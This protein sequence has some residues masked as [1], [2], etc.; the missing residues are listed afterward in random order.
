ML[1]FN[2]NHY[3]VLLIA[4]LTM[5]SA[6]ESKTTGKTGTLEFRYSADDDF[7]NFNKP[8][9]VGAKLDLRVFKAGESKVKATVESATSED[10]AVLKIGNIASNVVTIEAKAA[11]S[12]ELSFV[13]DAGEDSIDMMARVPEVLKVQHLC[14]SQDEKEGYY[15]QKQDIFIPF[16]MELKDG[17]SV[18]GYGYYPVTFDKETVTLDAAKSIQNFLKIK[19]GEEEGK[20]L[21]ES[22]IDETTLSLNIVK[23]GAI[24]GAKLSP[25]SGIV[26]SR[27]VFRNIL[28]TIDDKPICQAQTSFT[29]EVTTPDVCSVTK[30]QDESTQIGL[31]KKY[32]WVEI[33]GK[34]VGDCA[35]KVKYPKG[36]MGAGSEAELSVAVESK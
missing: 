34:T 21:M 31:T 30:V 4:A 25:D 29:I 6:C 14:L 27:T 1:K 20:V 28:P 8:I 18:I 16:D 26:A 3:T 15:L 17:Q 7:A 22:S 19:V 33:E 35:F 13:T 11:G 32:G 2:S 23:E 36:A 10:E 12:V 9:A 5:L 24:N